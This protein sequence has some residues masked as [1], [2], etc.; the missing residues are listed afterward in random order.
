MEISFDPRK[1]ERNL[2]ERGIAF[3]DVARF[4]FGTAI[5]VIDERRNYGELRVRALGFIDEVLFA[6]VYTMRNR[7]LRV[8]SLRRASRRER[9]RYDEVK[10][11]SD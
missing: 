4:N 3:E 8:I 10:R 6:L 2:E 1:S 11:Q 7:T 9:R 5:Y